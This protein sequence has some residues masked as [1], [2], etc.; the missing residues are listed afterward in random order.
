MRQPLAIPSKVD[1]SH[2]PIQD[3]IG[4]LGDLEN[5]KLDTKIQSQL[6]I[7]LSLQ[8]RLKAVDTQELSEFGKFCLKN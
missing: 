8:Y 2:P 5:C 6:Q 1:I 4:I 3:W 7:Y